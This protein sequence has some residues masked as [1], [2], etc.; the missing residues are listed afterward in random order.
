MARERSYRYTAVAIALHWAMAILLVF[1]IWLGWNMDD[2]ESRFQL[3]KSIG[4]TLLI[5][6]VAR[7]VWR[8]LNPPPPLPDMPKHESLASHLVHMGFYALMLGL[9]LGGWVL[10]SSSKFHVPTV[11]YG[12][13]SWPHLPFM[14]PFR[15]ELGHTIIETL[16]SKGAW[17]LLALL[18]LHVAGAVKHEVTGD[19]G[20]LRRM[21]PGI[22]GQSEGSFGQSRGFLAAFGGAFVLFGA[23]AAIPLL[24][25]AN[26]GVVPVTPTETLGDW[27]VNHDHSE[28]RFS[29]IHDG[30]TF[31]GTFE[32]WSAEIT[33]DPE[34]LDEAKATISLSSANASTGK[35][36]YD[37]SLI[38]AEWFDVGA[39]PLISVL[40]DGIEKTEAGYTA[41]AHITLKA[42][43]VTVPF[44]FDLNIDGDS[45]E[46]T[47]TSELSRA[48]LNLGQV[49]DPD[50]DWV[51][52][53]VTVAVS[54][55]ATRN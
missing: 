18:A 33:F 26:R 35:K 27:A 36:L 14:D 47:G 39:H 44:A 54:L 8:W 31:T 38:A 43:E 53:S 1:M 5:L 10:V 32:N 51:T 42:L 9:P 12:T 37:D 25:S 40:V 52:D 22:F 24:S 17:V 45:A 50:A 23:I 4:I 49:S 48:A 20:V 34:Q 3:H 28:I 41:D 30:D 6:T 55:S 19:E 16:H 2:H 21:L 46:M 7:I 29:G 15:T 13:V 11:L